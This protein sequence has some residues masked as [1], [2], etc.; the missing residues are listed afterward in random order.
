MKEYNLKIQESQDEM[1][2]KE[3]KRQNIIWMQQ[4]RIANDKILEENK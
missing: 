4:H 1:K 3:M 2:K